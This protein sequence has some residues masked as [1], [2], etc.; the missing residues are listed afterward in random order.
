MN[1]S[2]NA[3]ILYQDENGITNVNV[4]FSDQDVWLTPNQI[5]E[6]YDTTQPNISM[7]IDGIVNDGELPAEATHKKFLLVLLRHI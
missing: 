3:I 4:R 2:E 7:H 5:A 6:I 1:K